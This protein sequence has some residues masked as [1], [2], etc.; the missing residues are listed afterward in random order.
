MDVDHAPK[1]GTAAPADVP[2]PTTDA[3]DAA[4]VAAAVV[5]EAPATG[6]AP[7]DPTADA[8]TVPLPAPPPPPPVAAAPLPPP[9]PPKWTGPK[10]T[11]GVLDPYLPPVYLFGPSLAALS[12]ST[13]VKVLPDSAAAPPQ[14]FTASHPTITTSLLRPVYP[15]PSMYGLYADNPIRKGDLIGEVAGEVLAGELYRNDPINQYRSL[16][17]PKP[18]VRALGAPLNVVIDQRGFGNE[19]RFARNGCH[20]NAVVRPIVFTKTAP[21]AV[22]GSDEARIGEPTLLL[23]L[24]A[25]REIRGREEI[26]VPWDWD[27]EHIVH[28]LQPILQAALKSPS[29]S[30]LPGLA[31]YL[32]PKFAGVLT[33]LSSVFYTCVCTSKKDCSLAQMARVAEGKMLLGLA[34]KSG[35]SSRSARRQKRP[36]LGL[37]VGALRGWRDEEKRRAALAQET[38]DRIMAERA[39]A[40]ALRKAEALEAGGPVDDFDMDDANDH[41]IR[42]SPDD[43]DMDDADEHDGNLSDASTLTEPMSHFSSDP[44]SDEDEDAAGPQRPSSPADPRT[45]QRSPSLSPPPLLRTP[46]A[47]KSKAGVRRRP[48]NR[49]ESESP[50][51]SPPP[52]RPVVATPPPPATQQQPKT[53]DP[54]S[55]LSDVP[56]SSPVLS[57]AAAAR[58]SPPKLSLSMPSTLFAVDEEMSAPPVVEAPAAVAPPPPAT[59]PPAKEPTPP[60]KEP[61]PPPKPPTPPPPVK[62]MSLK[63]WAKRRKEAVPTPAA[64]PEEPVLRCVPRPFAVTA[65]RSLTRNPPLPRTALLLS[66]RPSRCPRPRSTSPKRWPGASR[67]RRPTRHRRSR[68]TPRRASR[69]I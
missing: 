22:A 12:S 60:P 64:T 45:P 68:R 66:P 54:D 58:S 67:P 27:D 44:E 39:A 34:D 48:N 36:D 10:A 9:S 11:F 4:P 35:G 52:A 46:P 25:N 30:S 29:S 1:A 26:S 49:V 24:F 15:R 2:P 18:G 41:S 65:G 16:G 33:H 61:T 55:P 47:A 57:D 23:G 63:D 14:T 50:P 40:A 5:A 3:A 38:I 59:A 32:Q 31:G 43:V 7:S 17:V 37:L 20:P 28:A 19:T 53:S 8:P 69:P 6:S 62:R 42:I 13:S 51:S 21:A 56:D